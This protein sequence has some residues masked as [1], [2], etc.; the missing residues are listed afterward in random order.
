MRHYLNSVFR[1]GV[2]ISLLFTGSALAQDLSGDGL[3]DAVFAQDVYNDQVC[4]GDGAG[5]FACEAIDKF[6]EGT[7]VEPETIPGV[8]TM[9]VA[10][11]D[12]DG[13]GATD[14]VFAVLAKSYAQENFQN[15]ICYDVGQDDQLC[16]P[17][18]Y[19]FL[20][21]TFDSNGARILYRSADV[22]LGDFN[23][24]GL[25]EPIFANNSATQAN[26][27]CPNI[28]A[29]GGVNCLPIQGENYVSTGVA[30]G[31]LNGN[32]RLDAVFA[33]SNGPVRKCMNN[34]AMSSS[35]TGL[36]CS[37]VLNFGS[38]AYIYKVEAGDLD[39]DGDVDLVMAGWPDNQV[40]LNDGSGNFSCSTVATSANNLA[41]GDVNNDGIPDLAFAASGADPI[42]L[43][44]GDGTFNC[45]GSLNDTR[46]SEAVA[47]GDV[48]GDGYLDA[49][50]ANFFARASVC[51]GDG[52]GSFSC[53]ASV[54]SSVIIAKDVALSGRSASLNISTDFS[55][56]FPADL[57]DSASAYAVEG[58]VLIKTSPSANKDDRQYVRSQRSDYN[59]VDFLAEVSFTTADP[60]NPMHFIGMG[61]GQ[62]VGFFNE[63]TGILFRIHPPGLAGGGV[64][65]G[66]RTSS[67]AQFTYGIGNITGAG[68]HRAQILKRGNN[69]SL[70][71][72][73]GY[74]ESAGFV[75]D[76]TQTVSLTALGSYLVASNSHI[77]FGTSSTFDYYDDLS[78]TVLESLDQPPV[79]TVPGD[80]TFEAESLLFNKVVSESALIE[81]EVSAVD[82]ED[83]PLTA[84]CTPR[85]GVSVAPGETTVRCTATD[86]AG[87]VTE[88]SFKITVLS[89]A[90][91]VT[92]LSTSIAGLD[93]KLVNQF[94]GKINDALAQLNSGNLQSA[95]GNLGALN[96]QI[97]AAVKSKKLSSTEG[98]ALT[99]AVNKLIGKL[100]IA[101]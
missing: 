77:Y 96:N 15:Y 78:V 80:L 73:V 88:T 29:T 64:D 61:P 71:I 51:L 97:N 39:G 26:S 17:M 37:D 70:S 43:G 45:A 2:G 44:N 74:D 84:V 98:Q 33:N 5:N 10:L 68:P 60:A 22:A 14:A 81:Y 42:C 90:D 48:N 91:Q 8:T 56:A 53:S 25:L 3:V 101:K 72:D 82:P 35:N 9:A 47:L 34:G 59:T 89:A 86:S 76:M 92:A 23:G 18:A 16:L 7:N 21:D 1:L 46:N 28:P 85:S 12:V 99:D 27:I 63:P 75:A 66:Y 93:A 100:Q 79:I 31:D 36:V 11:G 67:D 83:G 50:L 49:V 38:S 69:L 32:G 55:G 62:R 65:V 58:G 95:K 87:N 13:N 4:A 54:A 19:S 6:Y 52:T 57:E 94:S 41:I 20:S 30:V 24:D 40:C